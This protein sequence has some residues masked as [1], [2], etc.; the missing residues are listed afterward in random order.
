MLSK[1]ILHEFP[2]Y[3]CKVLYTIQR[4]LLGMF[5][6]L[7]FVKQYEKEYD[8]GDG[9]I[10]TNFVSTKWCVNNSVPLTSKVEPPSALPRNTPANEQQFH[11]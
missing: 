2:Y 6:L 8:E 7:N 5:W 4:N 3:G 9:V 10:D 1:N 11:V